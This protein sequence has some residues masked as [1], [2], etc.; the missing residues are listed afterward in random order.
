MLCR[1]SPPQSL[2]FGHFWRREVHS[3]GPPLAAGVLDPGWNTWMNV[4][5]DLSCRRTPSTNSF[6]Q[7][8]S[9]VVIA[10]GECFWKKDISSFSASLICLK[11]VICLSHTVTHVPLNWWSRLLTTSSDGPIVGYIWLLCSVVVIMFG[12]FECLIA[13]SPMCRLSPNGRYG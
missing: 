10:L 9:I 7:S 4:A 8:A 13:F 5:S 6:T 2:P 12:C 1:L 11:H 3:L